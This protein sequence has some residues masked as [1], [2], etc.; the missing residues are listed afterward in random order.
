MLI[1]NKAFSYSNNSGKITV[2]VS[3]NKTDKSAN[4]SVEAKHTAASKSIES[5]ITSSKNKPINKTVNITSLKG[6]S[7]QQSYSNNDSSSEY[8]YNSNNKIDNKVSNYKSRKKFKI[9]KQKRLFYAIKQFKNE[10]NINKVDLKKLDNLVNK[11]I[12]EIAQKIKFKF[13]KVDA[14]QL[15]QLIDNSNDKFK[16]IEKKAEI[17]DYVQKTFEVMGLLN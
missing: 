3:V 13:D 10:E 9:T 5:I 11:R 8:N 15:F 12:K 1:N 17:V 4:K 16:R 6:L 14:N 7:N 2:T